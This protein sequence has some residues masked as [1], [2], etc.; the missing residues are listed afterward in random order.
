MK[1]YYISNKHKTQAIV[2]KYQIDGLVQ[3][4]SNSIASAIELL[5]SCTKSSRWRVVFYLYVLLK[6]E[7]RNKRYTTPAM[8]RYTESTTL[9]NT[10]VFL[11]L[12]N[13]IQ[14]TIQCKMK[15]HS[16]HYHKWLQHYPRY[17]I[18]DSLGSLDGCRSS[19]RSKWA[20][21]TDKPPDGPTV[22]P[23]I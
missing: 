5:Q 10:W 6:T 21:M 4:C 18:I 2:E 3:D 9:S 19:Y 23:L 15:Q 16:G 13:I 11:Y 1:L 12:T 17:S 20:I 14:L 22:K 8:L 7:Q